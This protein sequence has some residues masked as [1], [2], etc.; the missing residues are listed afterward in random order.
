VVRIEHLDRTLFLRMLAEDAL[1]IRSDVSTNPFGLEHW[2][3]LHDV[4]G[5]VRFDEEIGHGLAQCLADDEAFSAGFAQG[6]ITGKCKLLSSGREDRAMSHERIGWEMRF[7]SALSAAGFGGRATGN[8]QGR[9]REQKRSPVHGLSS[10]EKGNQT[11]AKRH[12]KTKARV[13]PPF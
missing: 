9:E 1:Q 6:Q 3:R 7:K 4:D 13:Q 8:Q 12:N 5:A 11:P 2:A 10:S